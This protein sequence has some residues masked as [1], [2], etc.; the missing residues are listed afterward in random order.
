MNAT[1]SGSLS[2]ALRSSA[3]PSGISS[4]SAGKSLPQSASKAYRGIS[5]SGA[6]FYFSVLYAI[7][8]R[9]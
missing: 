8:S 2:A 1:E 5:S 4:V 7:A 6:N 3:S 9:Y